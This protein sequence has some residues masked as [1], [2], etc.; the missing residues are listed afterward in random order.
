M[1]RSNRNRMTRWWAA[2]ALLP[3]A[4][5]AC[6]SGATSPATDQTT[7]SVYV[8][9]A[10]GDVAHVWVQIDDVVLMSDS[11]NISLLQAPTDL[12]DLTTLQDE[13]M[14]LVKDLAIDPGAYHQLRFIL[15]GAV[16]ETTGGE[17]YSMGGLEAP[18]QAPTTGTLQ[19]P[20]CAQSGIKVSFPGDV[21]MDQGSANGVLLDFDVTQS[22]GHQAGNSGMWVMHPVIHGHVAPA[23]QI[24]GGNTGGSITGTVV[25]DDGNGGPTIPTCDGNP[26]S[27]TEFVPMATGTSTDFSGTTDE[28]GAFTIG[29]L[30]D[31]TY[32][33]G[34][35]AETTFTTYKLVW[36]ATANPTS[37]TID[38]QNTAV[39]G[40]VYTITAVTCEAI[41]P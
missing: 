38:A 22:F 19:C 11:G 33:L 15:G 34:Y 25:L 5:G 32:T 21:T 18:D 14:T 6:D 23:S 8:K 16:L 29:G 40:V 30:S 24:E 1:A 17:V 4:A 3:L 41:T 7:V 31:D 36:T 20:S 37:A 13:A 2:V 28:A 39:S 26:G 9:D 27:L 10:P 12:I 35:Q